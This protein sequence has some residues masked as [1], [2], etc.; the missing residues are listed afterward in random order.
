MFAMKLTKISMHKKILLLT[1]LLCFALL[2]PA[3]AA[4]PQ[5][6]WTSVD[7]TGKDF[8]AAEQ[9]TYKA[10]D[11]TAR[12]WGKHIAADGSTTFSQYE[13][14]FTKK[15]A[16]WLT[17]K[18]ARS[19]AVPRS[20][21]KERS[22]YTKVPIAPEST[23]EDLADAAAEKL[24]KPSLYGQKPYHWQL[25]KSTQNIDTYIL[26]DSLEY[27]ARSDAC[28][29]WVKQD[30]KA[31]DM[32]VMHKYRCFFSD[33]TIQNLSIKKMPREAAGT[34]SSNEAIYQAVYDAAVKGVF[35]TK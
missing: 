35:K 2:S 8:I 13:V 15:T 33:K 3:A 26:P 7:S 12:F 4:K 21:K 18:D 34:G 14:D 9:I 31:L 17:V 1:A 25:L 22:N 10:K 6:Q 16:T 24:G 5:W 30:L 27:D 29:I 28:D 23:M 11:N 32:T 19:G 20:F